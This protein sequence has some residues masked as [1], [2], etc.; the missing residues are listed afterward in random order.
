MHLSLNDSWQSCEARNSEVSWNNQDLNVNV[1]L[2][3]SHAF[4]IY[5]LCC[6]YIQTNLM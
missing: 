3:Y 4:N 1:E 6:Y 5:V 2:N